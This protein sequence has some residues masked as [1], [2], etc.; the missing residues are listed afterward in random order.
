MV[1]RVKYH[2]TVIY[3]SYVS[4]NQRVSYIPYIPDMDPMGI[5][6][7]YHSCYPLRISI[8]QDLLVTVSESGA[9]LCSQAVAATRPPRRDG[10]GGLPAIAREGGKIM[11]II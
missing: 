1:L 7:W 9:A 8:A 3:H 11:D 2:Q 6:L 4:H 5:S 10:G